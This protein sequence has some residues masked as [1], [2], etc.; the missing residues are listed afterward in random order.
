MS[1]LRKRQISQ[2]T[3]FDCY[4]EFACRICERSL[5]SPAPNDKPHITYTDTIKVVSRRLA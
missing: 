4:V 1:A 2:R 3:L 5:L